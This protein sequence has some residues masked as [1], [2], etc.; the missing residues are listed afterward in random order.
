MPYMQRVTP[1]SS[2]SP[3]VC[4]G[5]ADGLSLE[6]HNVDIGDVDEDNP[7]LI[8][9]GPPAFDEDIVCG[10]AG[11]TPFPLNSIAALPDCCLSGQQYPDIVKMLEQRARDYTSLFDEAEREALAA[12]KNGYEK[13]DA[14][15]KAMRGE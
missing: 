1:L 2:A 15:L 8:F 5:L 9:V 10:A 13:L 3:L 6:V 11:A 14:N 4:A 12:R 7:N